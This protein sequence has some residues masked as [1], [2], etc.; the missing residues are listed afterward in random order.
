MSNPRVRRIYDA[1]EEIYSQTCAVC[2][3]IAG[4]RDLR[5]M[6]EGCGARPAPWTVS[7]PGP[8]ATETDY[9]W[10]YNL[11]LV[12]RLRRRLA[13]VRD[14][15]I[16]YQALARGERPPQLRRYAEHYAAM[17]R[18]L[19]AERWRLEEELRTASYQS[20]PLLVTEPP[21]YTSN[22]TAYVAYLIPVA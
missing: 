11:S 20:W 22:L 9:P 10:P 16:Y 14:N 2:G 5:G 15:T 8:F 3:R 18:I 17:L 6:C 13:E 21:P 7:H 19:S 12:T 4:P 1:R